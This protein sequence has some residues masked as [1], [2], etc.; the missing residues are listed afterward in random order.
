MMTSSPFS[1]HGEFAENWCEKAP[2]ANSENA[3]CNQPAVLQSGNTTDVD[4]EES[5]QQSRDSV[6]PRADG[7]KCA[8]IFLAGCFTFEALVWGKPNYCSGNLTTLTSWQVFLS[9][10]AFSSHTTRLTRHSLIMLAALPS[11]EH[12]LPESCISSLLFRCTL[13]RHGHPFAVAHLSSASYSLSRP[14]LL[15]ASRQLSGI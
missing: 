3:A 11:L 5:G 12:V 2:S 9:P 8:W 7:G 1:A 13:S 6:T 14:S 15:Q 4:I 10:L